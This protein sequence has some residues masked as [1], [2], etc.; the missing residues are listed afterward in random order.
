MSDF[1]ALGR[2]PDREAA[3][4]PADWGPA[5]R[6]GAQSRTPASPERKGLP[7]PRRRPEQPNAARGSAGRAAPTATA[8]GR[9][10]WDAALSR[11]FGFEDFF[12]QK[13]GSRL[14]SRGV[15]PETV[16]GTPSG[17]TKVSPGGFPGR[18]RSPEAAGQRGA[19]GFPGRAGR[20]G[21]GGGGDSQSHFLE[22]GT[23]LVSLLRS[24][25]EA[26]H[27]GL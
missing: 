15:F 5:R 27:L 12:P 26:A 10:R 1:P 21:A 16:H 23:E 19:A 14:R 13:E 8:E 7:V 17:R 22:L 24:E 11:G 9:G 20:S 4:E 18:A 3:A 25:G 2:A 6:G